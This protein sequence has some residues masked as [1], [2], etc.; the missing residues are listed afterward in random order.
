M[1][2]VVGRQ[3]LSAFVLA[4]CAGSGVSEKVLN[5]V[6]ADSS[7]ERQKWESLGQNAFK[8][9]R[10]EEVRGEVVDGV[11]AGG[12]GSG[13]CDDQVSGRCGSVLAVS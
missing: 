1:A 10:G 5:Y 11:L 12:S 13:W 4:L 3:V 6:L 2:M 7:I 8:G 9:D